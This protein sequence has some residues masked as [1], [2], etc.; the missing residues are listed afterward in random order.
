[1]TDLLQEFFD[2]I[3][4]YDY[5]SRN[6]MDV[7]EH[8]EWLALCF[9][10]D[11]VSPEPSAEGIQDLIAKLV[12]SIAVPK[13]LPALLRSQFAPGVAY[14]ER[15]HPA[16]RVTLL[17]VGSAVM[18]FDH[19]IYALGELVGKPPN[20]TDQRAGYWIDPQWTFVSTFVDRFYAC[21]AEHMHKADREQRQQKGYSA[22]EVLR[23]AG[24]QPEKDAE[25]LLA[26]RAARVSDLRAQMRN[27]MDKQSYTE[28]VAIQESLFTRLLSDALE[29]HGRKVPERLSDVVDA[30]C[31]LGI[32]RD[33][34][35]P[36][37]LWARVHAWRKARNVIIH[38]PRESI[39]AE[40]EPIEDALR[41]AESAA[42]DGKALVAEI[43]AWSIEAR[44]Q[45][46]DMSL[47]RP[48]RLQ[49]TH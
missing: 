19:Y 24:L 31:N 48:T 44:A 49:P 43:E 28:A 18:I 32:E 34:A 46:L 33:I 21:I 42:H 38:A 47:P 45:S 5:F 6:A 4:S 16:G 12:Q 39:L 9:H 3:R 17:P 26:L 22:F 15:T 37:G 10:L 36:L 2:T 25:S 27:A 20:S 14:Q 29:M 13:G 7:E 35:V 11:R 8:A 30:A 23:L 40:P 41:R 1:M